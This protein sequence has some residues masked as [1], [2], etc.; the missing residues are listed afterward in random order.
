MM[1]QMRV[2]MMQPYFFPYLG[3]FG[4]IHATDCWVVF[5][6]AQYIRR[7]W[8]NRNR[9]LSTGQCPWKYAR[10]PVVKCAR[11]TPIRDVRIDSR[12]TWQQDLFNSFDV[13]RNRKAPFYRSTV[14]FLQETLSIKTDVLSD[15]LVHCLKRTCNY[16][17]LPI[18][19][20]IFSDMPLSRADIDSP[21]DWTCQTSRQ[22]GATTYVN[23]PGGRSIYDPD[24]FQKAG[25]EL[26]FLEH[27]LPPYDQGESEFVAGLSIIDAL[28]WNDVETVREMVGQYELRE[29]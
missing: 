12:Q 10:V 27:K 6:T 7:G 15:L 26:R 8:V 28:M 11:S 24:K 16:L 4:L 22:L 23:P 13:Y 2:G 18:D 17:Q 9:V 19:C 29:T 14:G 1:S 21:G 3:Y 5:D 20:R 25:L